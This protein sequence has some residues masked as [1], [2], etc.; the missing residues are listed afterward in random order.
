MREVYLDNSHDNSSGY[1]LNEIK[2][3]I[4]LYIP[5]FM[6]Y[7]PIPSWILRLAVWPK[8]PT[9]YRLGLKSVVLGPHVQAGIL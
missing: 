5:R 6:L 8:L 7:L 1:Y 3:S 4:L 9:A 2:S